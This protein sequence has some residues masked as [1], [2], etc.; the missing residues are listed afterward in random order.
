MPDN[1]QLLRDAYEAFGRGD[2]PAVM[3]AFADD[4]S[5]NTPDVL[6]HGRTV[7]GKDA[8]GGFFQGLAEKW[9]DFG[10]ELEDI[11]AAG[12]RGYAV[13]RASGTYRGQPAGYGF[14]HAWTI[15]DGLCT[16]FEEYVDPSPELVSAAAA[17]TTA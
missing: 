11:R 8:V 1:A 13:G 10:L 2:I 7:S 12:D 16:R 6:P 9:D 3:D 5:W 17:A 14:V 4:I 15:A